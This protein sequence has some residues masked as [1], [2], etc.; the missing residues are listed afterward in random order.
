MDRS[1]R[2]VA[3]H[4]VCI[5]LCMSDTPVL[6]LTQGLRCTQRKTQTHPPKQTHTCIYTQV[7]AGQVQCAPLSCHPPLADLLF[8]RCSKRLLLMNYAA[9]GPCNKLQADSTPCV[10]LKIQIK[11]EQP[12]TNIVFFSRQKQAGEERVHSNQAR[13][14]CCRV[15]PVGI[16]REKS[17]C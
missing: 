3:V 5:L 11:A 2:N 7:A 9:A 8:S 15:G 1:L 4:Q 14:W 17:S 6:I 12:A 10:W 16:R 13:L